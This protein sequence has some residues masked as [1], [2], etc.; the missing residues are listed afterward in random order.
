MLPALQFP[1][2]VHYFGIAVIIDYLSKCSLFSLS[3]APDSDPVLFLSVCGHESFTP[4]FC[5][6]VA[7]SWSKILGWLWE[8]SYRAHCC[9]IPFPVHVL[10][11]SAE[12]ILMFHKFLF[13][14]YTCYLWW[15]IFILI[16]LYFFKALSFIMYTGSSFGFRDLPMWVFVMPM[17]VLQ[18]PDNFCTFDNTVL[19]LLVPLDLS[20]SI[21]YLL[22]LLIQ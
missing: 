20:D 2:L 15:Y 19:D 16:K 21:L 14:P 8:P 7:G 10:I 4:A 3:F 9:H 22:S 6:V 17:F 5:T 18:G 12:S 1:F 13:C 11:S